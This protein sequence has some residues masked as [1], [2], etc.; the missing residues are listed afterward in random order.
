MYEVSDERFEEMVD[1]AF[2]QVPQKFLDNMRNV[3]VLI[4]DYNPDSR[5]ILGLY[6]GTA[7]PNRVFGHGGLPDSITIYKS[8]L[9]DH[10]HSEEQLAEQVRV[11]VL[12]EVGHYFGLDEDDLHRLGYA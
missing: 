8:A 4:D 1:D 10:C 3:V 2:D 12:H 9:Q 6:S 7:L 5:H 11:T